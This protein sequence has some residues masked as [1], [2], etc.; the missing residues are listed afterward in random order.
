MVVYTHEKFME[1][2]EKK[3]KPKKEVK[4]KKEKEK[5]AR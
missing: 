2:I 3:K 5:N 4:P 1:M